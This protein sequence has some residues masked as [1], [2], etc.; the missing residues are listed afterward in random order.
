MLKLDLKPCSWWKRAELWQQS[1]DQAFKQPHAHCMMT[2]MF[3]EFVPRIKR[4]IG[5]VEP[6]CMDVAIR[7]CTAWP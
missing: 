5:N 7:D 1:V 6:T 4:L 3:S 2:R